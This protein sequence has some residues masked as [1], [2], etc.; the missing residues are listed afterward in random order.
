[1]ILTQ[2]I[3]NTR[4][5]E[6]H[7]RPV[8][9]SRNGKQSRQ[10]GVEQQRRLWEREAARYDRQMGFW[11]R[12][13]FGDARAWAC[14]QA[15][16][17]VLEVAIGTG[18]NLPFY[19][20]QVQITGIDLSPAMLA[21]AHTRA[22]ELNR[23]VEL[24]EGDA[25]NL[26]YPGDSF[27]TVVC[28][29]SLCNITDER[30]AIAEMYRVLRPGGRLILT[31]HVASPSPILLAGQRLFEKLTFRLAG[32]HQTR[33]PLPIVVETGFTLEHQQRYKKGIVER[34]TARKPATATAS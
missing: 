3:A 19:P 34:L 23:L 17:T 22:D 27:D 10:D 11:E 8:S 7:E 1:V 33:R 15:S 18:R 31:D 28:T 16:G 30:Q 5:Q 9:I 14:Q 24:A 29:F 12:H 20:A 26:P 32:D 13:L 2:D 4:D 25:H 6:G 21:I